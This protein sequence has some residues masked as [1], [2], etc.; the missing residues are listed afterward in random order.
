[1][2]RSYASQK[3][4]SSLQPKFKECQLE[5]AQ[6]EASLRP[7]VGLISGIVRNL[8][9]GPPL[10]N[11]LDSY[12]KR[13]K[14]SIK[15]QPKFLD[16]VE[17]SLDDIDDP[18][19]SYIQRP[20]AKKGGRSLGSQDTWSSVHDEGDGDSTGS[21]APIPEGDEE[22]AQSPGT[23]V[24][25]DDPDQMGEGHDEEEFD[26]G[27]APNIRQIFPQ[28]YSDL[29]PESMKLDR[30]MYFT[31]ATIVKGP[32]LSLIQDLHGKYAR[33]T[34]AI[35]TLWKHAEIQQSEDWML[36]NRCRV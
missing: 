15:T 3:T 19:E 8:P 27:D 10:E 28:K 29:S 30:T 36:C 9:D 26:M 11:F 21:M 7:W 2:S 22:Q 35:I 18:E 5:S 12:L 33:Y 24:F 17:L 23:G 13:E 20:A 14:V 31:L 4:I 16:D 32:Y 34:F 25:Q 1:M 6:G